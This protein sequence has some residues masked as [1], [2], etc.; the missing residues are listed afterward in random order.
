[1]SSSAE[2]GLRHSA[3]QQCLWTKGMTAIGQAGTRNTSEKGK[4][5]VRGE[6]KRSPAHR[7]PSEIP[8]GMNVSLSTE[9]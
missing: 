9:T 4:Q 5:S 3:C 2:D 7:S 1:M 6:N 8:W